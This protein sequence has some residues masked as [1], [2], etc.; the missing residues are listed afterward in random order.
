MA[1]TR[2]KM[3]RPAKLSQVPLSRQIKDFIIDGVSSGELAP[4]DRIP[5]EAELAKQFSA[6]RMTVNRAV[7]ELTVEGRLNRVQG[8]GTF[9]AEFKPLAPLFE[10]R[11]IAKEIA[12]Q[13]HE[14]SSIPLKSERGPATKQE[15]GRLEVPVGT[16]ILKLQVLHLSDGKPIQIE[17][18][19]VVPKFAPEF[20]DQDYSETTASDYLQRTVQFTEVEHKLDAVAAG[21]EFG[22]LL[23]ID[24]IT[25]CLR[26]VR[27]TWLRDDIITY[28]QLIHPGGAFRF[29]GRFKGPGNVTDV[30]F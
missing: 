6:S 9:V 18:R 4:G 3:K 22:R 8:L 19:L 14:H 16:E 26:L 11:S 20:L 30:P 17:A 25:P 27:R 29:T 23:E 15:A 10:V 7:S 21:P 2:H 28:V 13:G 12:D 5:S 24:E 1:D